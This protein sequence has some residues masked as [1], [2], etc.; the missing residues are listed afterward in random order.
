MVCTYIK[1]FFIVLAMSVNPF[2]AVYVYC[3][4][5]RK[6]LNLI[7]VKRCK[8]IKTFT[9]IPKHLLDISPLFVSFPNIFFS[10]SVTSNIGKTDTILIVLPKNSFETSYHY[11]SFLATIFES[12]SFLAYENKKKAIIPDM[13]QIFVSVLAMSIN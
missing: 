1:I 8:F 3:F 11:K 10:L 13:Y 6:P 9:F 2:R 4:H 12:C 7:S 5:F